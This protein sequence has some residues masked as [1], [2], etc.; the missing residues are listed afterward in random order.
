MKDQIQ[1]ILQGFYRLI[2]PHE[3]AVFSV[4][5]LKILLNG[6]V[7]VDVRELQRRTKYSGGYSEDARVI[8]VTFLSGCV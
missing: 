7:E 8:E 1:C 2:P 5:Q 3:I 6:N 4:S